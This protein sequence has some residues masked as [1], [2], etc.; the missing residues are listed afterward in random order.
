[1]KLCVNKILCF[2]DQNNIEYEYVGDKDMEIE[3]F[4]SL[5]YLKDNC[6][7][8]IKKAE[9]YSENQISGYQDMLMVIDTTE[10]LDGINYINCK[11][12]KRVFFSILD[13]FWGNVRD[14]KI[15]RTSVVETKQI[16]EN[17]YIGH[18][19]FINKDVVIG[20]NVTIMHNV[21]I[22]CPTVIKDNT[23]IHSGVIIGTDGFGYYQDE[24]G[25]NQKV[26]H[27]GG[28]QI[29]ADVEVGANT[30]IDRGTIDDTVI[31]DNVKIDDLC[32]IAHNSQIGKNA[33]IVGKTA[34]G[35]STVV[36]DNAYVAP[37]SAIMNQVK[38][39]KGAYVGMGSIVLKDVKEGQ[40][41]FGNPARLIK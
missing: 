24:D 22:V 10:K 21:T 31:G 34:I 13:N 3:S 35:G 7:F 39:E 37:S 5:N 1:M 9:N 26:M 33:M 27:Y 20:N 25:M 23:I 18:H 32:L 19:C 38:V 29:G 30:C 28:V 2:L 4:C 41:V 16:G 15:E 8:W 17:V 36:G 11:N 40:K 6:I 14:N 12:P